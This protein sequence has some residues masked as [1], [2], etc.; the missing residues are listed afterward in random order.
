VAAAAQRLA[1]DVGAVSE[2][3]NG[4]NVLHTAASR[5]GGM[6]L[7]LV[8]GEGGRDVAGILEG[9]EDGSIRT[10]FLIGADELDTAR[11]RKALVVYQGSHGDRGAASADVILPGCA[12]TEKNASY[13]NLEGR[14]QRTKLAVFPPGE[15]KEDWRALRALSEVLGKSVALNSLAQ[16]RARVA[17]LAP[18]LASPD[19]IA[20]A[21]WAPSEV[22]GET[23]SASFAS[24][25]TD[26]YL[27][28]PISRASA[29]MQECSRLFVRGE[30]PK[31]TGTYG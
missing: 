25:I 22:R 17:E 13:V 21:V 1:T 23:L 30:E 28:N 16:V 4:F 29:V 11:L 20:P 8:P 31:A 6:E 7:G 15:A 9:V 19:Q 3:W 10:V 27:T 24:G 5:V 18:P 26:F 14:L 12:Y 2:G